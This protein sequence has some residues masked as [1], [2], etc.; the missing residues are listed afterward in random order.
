MEFSYRQWT[1]NEADAR[2]DDPRV[3]ASIHRAVFSSNTENIL[4]S[5]PWDV[6]VVDECHHLSDWAPGGGDPR[7]NFRLVRDLLEGLSPT[8]RV[9][10]LSGTP[11]Q[12]HVSRFE[13]LLNLLR[14]PGE[15]EA[16]LT[17]RVI[18]RT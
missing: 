1:A 8:G 6:L 14:A 16:A 18:Y 3:L 4:K 7:E 5:G 12:G 17:G 10:F 2:L 11:H 13:N 9:L 15:D